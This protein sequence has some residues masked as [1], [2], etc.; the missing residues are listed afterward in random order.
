MNT[1]TLN[2]TTVQ[3]KRMNR[4]IWAEVV[5]TIILAIAVFLLTV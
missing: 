3:Q 1:T 5:L 2:T 4:K